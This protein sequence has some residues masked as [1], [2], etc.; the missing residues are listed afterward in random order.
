MSPDASPGAAPVRLV[1]DAVN[2]RSPGGVQLQLELARSAARRRPAGAELLFLQAEGAESTE[3]FDGLRV[4]RCPPAQGW[5]G[6]GAWFAK[7]LPAIARARGGNVVY[8]L[9]GILS[10]AL[11][12]D[13]ATVNS[14]NNMLPF[15][16]DQIRHFPLWSPDRIRF[17][18][19]RLAYVWSSKRADALVVP[20]R[21]AI[22]A[23]RPYAGDL[24]P[25]SFVARNPIPEHVRVDPERPPAHPYDGR[26]YFFYLSVVFW[27]KN[28][29]NLIE[30]YRRALARAPDLPDLLMAGRPTETATVARIE[31]ALARGGMGAKARFL[32]SIDAERIPAMLHHATVNVFPSLCETSSFVQGEILG[33]RGVMACSDIPPMPEVSAGA[34]EL[35]DPHDPDA[36][37]EVLLRLWRDEA[38]R[39]DLRRRA[40]AAAAEL[41]WDACG[42]AMW[43]A[44]RHALDAS[45]SRRRA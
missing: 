24:A 9:S 40:D 17:L 18:L 43:R 39:A 8:S 23:M 34:A 3:P 42:D 15:A 20:S 13:F 45:L 35:F 1:L 37:A 5:R 21:F 28:H 38:R 6:L 2:V 25:K 44:A 31:A 41:T 27:Y 11:C 14:I 33:A 29:L 36:I 32:G 30:G 22:D 12:R 19:L 10:P 4:E 26:P 16:P 7:G